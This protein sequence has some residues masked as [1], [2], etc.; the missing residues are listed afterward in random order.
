MSSDS[1]PA[2]SGTCGVCGTPLTGRLGTQCARCLL[3]LGGGWDGP[4]D[5]LSDED[6]LDRHQVRRF[7]DYELLE[8]IARGGMGVVYRARQL[9][10][11]REVAVKM[12]LAG[13]L[14]GK[15]S[16][17]MF[18]REAHAAA[19]LHH[20]NIVP[21]YEIGEYEL[22]HY[23]TMRLV[24]GGRNIAGWAASR[25]GRWR[26]IA[27]ATAKAAHAVA[28]AHSHGVLHRDL[29]P[30]N[31]LWDDA[32][33]PQVT[34]FGLAKLLHESDGAV[35][36]SAR[37]LG[38][39]NYMAPEQAAGHDAEITTTT[40]VY[41]L[42]AVLYELLSGRPPFSGKSA[43]DTLRRVADETPAPLPEVPKDLWT[44]CL[45]CLAKRSEDRYASAS[46]L[47]ADLER[48][49]RGEP[50]S[51]VPLT[52]LQSGWRWARR[53]PQ[54]ATLLG[55][56]VASFV[57]GIAGILWQWRTAELA[58]HG[59]SAALKKATATVVDLYVHSG[60][61]A[62][63]DD[64]GTR[65]ALWFAKAAEASPD[66]PRQ[67]ENLSRHAA[68]RDDSPTAIR[69]FRS[70]IGPIYRLAWNRSGTALIGRTWQLKAAVWDADKETRWKPPGK[71]AMDNALWANE[72]EW[73]ISVGD[74]YARLTEYPSGRELARTPCS[75]N[76]I[77]LALS[78]DDR[79]A[80]VGGDS[81]L[82][83]DLSTGAT[84]PLPKTKSPPRIMDFS[85]DARRLLICFDDLVGICAT[86]SQSEFLYPPVS[87]VIPTIPGFLG[88]DRFFT[89]FKN[90]EVAVVD[91]GSGAQVETY[92]YAETECTPRLASPDGRFIATS[93]SQPIERP[94]GF[95]RHASHPNRVE[96]N[97]F[98][99]DSTLLAT[100][101]Y[102]S[103]VRLIPLTGDSPVRKI[104]WHQEGALGVAISP[105]GL[106]LA[107][108]QQ[109][110]ELVRI[111]RLNTPPEPRKIPHSGY[112]SGFCL[113]ADGGRIAPSGTTRAFMRLERTRVYSTDTAEPLGPEIVPGGAIMNAA[114]APDASWLAL[115]CSDLTNRFDQAFA[116]G[117]GSGNLQFWNYRDSSR[118]G[119]TI[120][121]PAEPRGLAIH[122]SGRW[123]A[124]Y[125]A[126]RELL[127]MEVSTRKF[128][129]LHSTTNSHFSS[130]IY[131]NGDCRYSPDGRFLAA[132]AMR[133][134]A[135]LWD[136]DRE[137]LVPI[138]TAG[139]SQ[140]ASVDFHGNLL[141]TVSIESRIEFFSLP[142]A[143]PARAPLQDTDW[144]F[145]GRFSPDGDLFLSG[146]RGK[147]ARVWDWRRGEAKFSALRH[148]NEVFAG[149]FLPESGCLATGGVDRTIRIW[150]VDTGLP[151]RAPLL[152]D[153]APLQLDLTPDGRTLVAG[154]S[155][156]TNI[157]LFDVAQ[158]LPKPQLS[159]TDALLLAEIDAA[160]E[161]K[162]GGLE[163][164]GAAAW[165]EKWRQFRAV[166]PAWHRW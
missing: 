89:T 90:S 88:N 37:V 77:C 72:A 73:F 133:Q 64:D 47:A 130:D 156:D 117:G 150:D 154:M 87:C 44:V 83:W 43:I 34:D 53:R 7:G 123:L 149:C 10:L 131:S 52:P 144:L 69:A 103:V 105:D 71:F 97:D 135:V 18:R 91:A 151:R 85:E 60:L 138:Q 127:E 28:F 86:D 65:A 45:K 148:E 121:L 128:R 160:A 98:S 129:V 93:Q 4:T 126:K 162:N 125:T 111:W 11:N 61:T 155:G 94:A 163:P 140:V 76:A 3:G 136:R 49:A 84:K 78:R 101:C 29:K 31:I 12:I 115:I 9:S 46:D 36:L 8:E 23:F 142:D 95:I 20:P 96:Q 100:A 35:T 16:L 30:S 112:N 17:R 13:E 153:G 147:I 57:I 102:D 161:I 120:A 165:F 80:A 99:R 122:S 118:M 158:L 55:V 42:G 113:S 157:L 6:F 119:E 137:M 75:M 33:G 66:E 59:E 50:V 32:N 19:N 56:T 14:A 22:Q 41:G 62:A 39:P 124:I 58:R 25:R 152:T 5:A 70:E 81:P 67:L 139:P 110:V 146:G 132:W 51:A 104:G 106:R 134:P 141:S 166:H 108:S 145:L 2:H 79:W 63:K 116:T 82:I 107:T 24:A 74:G 92:K 40:D 159:P 15:D 68:W 38:S 54:L 114:F 21:V 27:A 109:G 143:S 1:N 48:F 164:L 26:E